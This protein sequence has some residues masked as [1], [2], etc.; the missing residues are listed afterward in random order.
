MSSDSRAVLWD[1]D[2]TL[3]DSAGFHW[4]SWR[5]AMQDAGVEITHEQFIES[6]GK[7][8]DRILRGWLGPSAGE[9]RIAQVGD[10]KEVRYRA[11]VRARGLS[12]LPGA[13]EWVERL[14]AERWK[15]AVC[16]SAPRKNIE[17]VL[18]VLGLTRY[19]DTTVAAEDVTHG[20]PD[21]EVFLLG[22]ERLCVPASRCIVVEDAPAGVEAARRAGMHSVGVGPKHDGLPADIAVGSLANLAP[23]SLPGLLARRI[24]RLHSDLE[25]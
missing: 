12:A 13:A 11:L 24:D 3:V 10:D 4:Q 25:S 2:G 5:E 6:F 16:S 8:N 21:P 17:V 20:K 23:D 1:L 18:D 15:Q 9:E 19:F 7:R 14:H 22:A